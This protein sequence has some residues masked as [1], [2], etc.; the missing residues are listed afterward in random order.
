M[1][2]V[3]LDPA[4]I[5]I[6][7]I[8]N[9]G[10][11]VRRL[12]WLRDGGAE[13]LVWADDPS[14]ELLA[15]AAELRR[16]LPTT[17]ELAAFHVVWIA[18]LPEAVAQGLAEAVR[19]LGRLVNVEDVNPLCDFHTPAVVRR[20]ALTLSAGTGGGS[21]AVAKAARERLAEAFAPTWG[22]A[23]ADIAQARRRLKDQGADAQT[24]AADARARLQAFGI[25][26]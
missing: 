22:E 12:R 2:P 10:L 7:L 11:T 8:G 19:A 4:M 16:R 24:V 14:A 6:A 1:I 18:D 23:L 21:P 13:P 5:R 17:E 26:P 9:G 25:A 3:H 20:G 15:A